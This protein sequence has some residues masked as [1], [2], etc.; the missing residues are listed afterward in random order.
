MRW[1]DCKGLSYGSFL[2]GMPSL[3]IC[4]DRIAPTAQPVPSMGG[5]VVDVTGAGYRIS[6]AVRAGLGSSR[7]GGRFRE[8]DIEMARADMLA[9]DREDTF[10]DTKYSLH[11]R[12]M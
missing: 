12:G 6:D 3:N 11:V 4:A 2:V 9:F 1:V 8:V 5:H 10:E 7:L